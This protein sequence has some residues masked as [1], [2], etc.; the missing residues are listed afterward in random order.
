MK[1]DRPRRAVRCHS[2]PCRSVRALH[3]NN[4]SLPVGRVGQALTLLTTMWHRPLGSCFVTR[5]SA[6][7]LYVACSG[8]L[9]PACGLCVQ[10][11]IRLFV[12][13]SYIF[14]LQVPSSPF[15]RMCLSPKTAFQLMPR[16]GPYVLLSVLLPIRHQWLPRHFCCPLPLRYRLSATLSR[17]P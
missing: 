5:F 1:S 14:V 3:F 4:Y 17:C 7:R 16:A 8:E 2:P 15:V 9:L 12:L 6:I 13:N 11:S 10:S